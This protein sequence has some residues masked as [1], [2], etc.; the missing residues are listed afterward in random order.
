KLDGK[1]RLVLTCRL[2]SEDNPG[3][4]RANSAAALVEELGMN[5][6][7]VELGSV[8][9]RRLHQVYRACDIYV[10][11]AYA[12]SFAHPLVEAMA[13]GLPIAASDLAVHREITGN[14]ALFFD[15]FSHEELAE[16]VIEIFHS[17]DLAQQ[18]SQRGEKRSQDFSWSR[19]VTELM[20]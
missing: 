8:P 17:R 9:Y 15:R 6:H 5:D 2:R 1:V 19:H 20:K 11:A 18:M 7:V 13:C 12:E 10:T 3:S 4:Y 14:E 16:R